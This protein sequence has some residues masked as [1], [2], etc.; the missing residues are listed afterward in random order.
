MILTRAGDIIAKIYGTKNNNNSLLAER[1]LS[2]RMIFN[3]TCS[4]M[5][6]DYYFCLKSDFTTTI[7]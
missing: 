5:N 3:T 6:D 7:S 4:N 1:I 2:S